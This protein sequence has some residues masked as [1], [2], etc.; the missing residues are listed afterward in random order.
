[1]SV[2]TMLSAP[3]LLHTNATAALVENRHATCPPSVQ[4]RVPIAV[5]WGVRAQM[6]IP[7]VDIPLA[8]ARV[9]SERDMRVPLSM[10]FGAGRQSA[11]ERVAAVRQRATLALLKSSEL[12]RVCQLPRCR[13]WK[14]RWGASAAAA[15]VWHSH[16]VHD[17]PFSCN[18]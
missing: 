16:A 3:N 15:A 17:L 1:M 6:F 14:R 11:S 9:D 10:L 5:C 4:R 12:G 18:P 8:R 13:R 7:S 2:L